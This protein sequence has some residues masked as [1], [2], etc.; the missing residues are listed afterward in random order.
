MEGGGTSHQTR[1][2]SARLGDVIIIFTCPP[3]TTWFT[4]PSPVEEPG[5]PHPSSGNRESTLVG[6]DGRPP[7][8]DPGA[9]ASREYRC[10]AA[11]LP[12]AP[13]R[14]GLPQPQEPA[15]DGAPASGPAS[16][17]PAAQPSSKN[18][19]N[20]RTRVSPAPLPRAGPSAGAAMLS[21]EPCDPVGHVSPPTLKGP[22]PRLT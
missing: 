17:P 14:W 9:F 5:D 2:A 18:S 10:A 21:R 19:D 20:K 16:S 1:S 6:G 3:P 15:R 12:W 4:H 7:G 8:T 11:E 22:S 13:G